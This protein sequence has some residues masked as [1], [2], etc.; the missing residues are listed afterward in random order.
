M[1]SAND[2][3]SASQSPSSATRYASVP[4]SEAMLSH[5]DLYHLVLDGIPIRVF[6]KD[7]NSVYLGANKS[8]LND[9]NMTDEAHIL[10]K[11]DYDLPWTKQEADS[12]RADDHEVMASGK[13]KLNI[14]EPQTHAGGA[15]TWLRTNKIPLRNGDGDVIGILGTYEN[16]TEIKA[17]EQ[18]LARSE[19]RFRALVN[20]TYQ[21]IGLLDLD[22]RIIMAN[23]TVANRFRVP[24]K[25]LIGCYFP[26]SVFWPESEKPKLLNAISRCQKGEFVRFKTHHIL[27]DG[28]TIHVDFSL[29]PVFGENGEVESLLPEGRDITEQILIEQ[30][31]REFNELLE[32]RVETRTA[33]LT[34]ANA[35]L[36]KTLEIVQTTQAELIESEKMATIGSLVGS[37]THDI[38][39]PLGIGVTAVSFMEERLKH[40]AD[41]LEHETL[42]KASLESDLQQLNECA[43]LLKTNLQRS[44][45]LV[46]GFKQITVDQGSGALRQINL[47]DYLS[48]IVL[49]LRPKL[50]KA[51]V[52]VTIDVPNDIIWTTCPG[53]IAQIVTNLMMNSLHHAFTD[54]ASPAISLAARQ[55]GNS[56][57][58]NY[59]DNGIG[60]SQA[61]LEHLYEPFYTTRRESGGSGVG[62]HSVHNIVTE[63]LGG[64]LSCSSE[65][66]HGTHFE[67]SL[68]INIEQQQEIT[69]QYIHQ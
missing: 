16:V 63:K 15:M 50:R 47:G 35:E 44:S 64:E 18:A 14:I 28:D 12:F 26:D 61:V 3:S 2:K 9:C 43:E 55:E 60:M 13:A 68:P 37:F 46:Q 17:K 42:S 22:G 51:S 8:F 11:T 39:T 19:A 53:F 45:E 65:P 21:F 66:G 40:I 62:M 24:P 20:Q 32:Q 31:L 56:I 4:D 59:Q 29:K 34:A 27:P 1:S 52:E 48:D 49:S 33:Q 69:C 23:D 54:I 30:Q 41:G 67:I 25:E 57:Q 36:S 10:G 6:W 7:S 58:L 38:N 5:L